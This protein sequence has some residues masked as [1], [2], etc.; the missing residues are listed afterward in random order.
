M[1]AALKKAVAMEPNHPDYLY[2]M[3]FFYLQNMRLEE[4]G[5]IAEKMV[6]IPSARPGGIQ[7]LKTIDKQRK[8]LSVPR[9]KARH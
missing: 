6:N 2:A 9:K 7:I 8:N 5:E 3:A 1:E 4:A